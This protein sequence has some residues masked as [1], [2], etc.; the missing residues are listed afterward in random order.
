MIPLGDFLDDNTPM[1]KSEEMLRR[2]SLLQ[3]VSL[4]SF[5]PDE[6]LLERVLGRQVSL[7]DDEREI[8]RSE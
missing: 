7:E 3:E 2:T 5:E 1:P 6:K 4:A 8:L